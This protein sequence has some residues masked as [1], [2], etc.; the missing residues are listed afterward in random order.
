MGKRRVSTEGVRSKGAEGSEDPYVIYWVL[1]EEE[2]ERGSP[3]GRMQRRW[4]ATHPRRI[5]RKVAEATRVLICRARAL[6]DARFWEEV[7]DEATLQGLTLGVELDGP[8][9]QIDFALLQSLTTRASADASMLAMADRAGSLRRISLVREVATLDRATSDALA[10]ARGLGLGTQ[11]TLRWRPDVPCDTSGLLSC[12]P[13][14]VLDR[15]HFHLPPALV[16]PT[17]GNA[18]AEVLAGLDKAAR[19]RAV[20]L[21]AS[22]MP[23]LRRVRD[24][25]EA[26]EASAP[27]GP[28]LNDG[29]GMM[30]IS[31]RLDLWP[32][33]DLRL[34]CGNLLFDDL[35]SVYRDSPL[36]RALRNR[37]LVTG[38]C[39]RC[40]HAARCGGSRALAYAYFG[41]PLASDPSCPFGEPVSQPMARR[42]L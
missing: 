7:V 23:M 21:S 32:S 16:R 24:L 34:R 12:I 42:A 18:L 40:E 10:V 11:L 41:D 15:L 8:T 28:A 26:V 1:A 17:M 37:R 27:R 6:R 33:P 38:K 9:E 39:G 35:L 25:S 13:W 2:G 22:D 14:T 31:P 4:A 20:A 5:V 30:C 19:A 36:M 3:S 29:R